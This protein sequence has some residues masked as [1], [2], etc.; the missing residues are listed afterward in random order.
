MTRL[1]DSPDVKKWRQ[2][3]VNGRIPERDLLLVLP[4]QY[5]VDLHQSAI[6]YPPAARA[7][8]DLLIAAKEAGHHIRV[9]YSYRTIAVQ[10]AK[11]EN[12]QAGGNLAAY[13]G[14]SNHGEGLAVDFTD[15][16]LTDTMWLQD[17]ARV[18]RFDNADAPSEPWHWTYR[19]GYVP[20]E[21]PNMADPRFDELMDGVEKFNQGKPAPNSGPGAKIYAA[22]KKG[23]KRPIPVSGSHKHEVRV[24][25]A[26]IE[27]GVGGD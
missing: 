9:K 5:D 18:F 20:E 14:T 7:C 19:G 23:E 3:T 1:P 22:L 27:T 10:W 25:G 6:L 15:M 8:T 26:V 13:P 24:P 11:W 4:P 17:F 21:E 16:N 12:Y 2:E